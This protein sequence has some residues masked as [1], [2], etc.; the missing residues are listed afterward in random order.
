VGG[1][2]KTDLPPSFDLCGRGKTPTGFEVDNFIIEENGKWWDL[3]S[4]TAAGFWSSGL[5]VTMA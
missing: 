3:T 2:L 5:L 1:N 4:N